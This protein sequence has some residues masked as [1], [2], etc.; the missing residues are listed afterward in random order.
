MSEI[1]AGAGG[2]SV[3]VDACAGD[4]Q[5]FGK[6]GREIDALALTYEIYRGDRTDQCG[7]AQWPV[8]HAPQVLVELRGGTSLDGG[9]PGA[10]GTQ[11]QTVE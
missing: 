2:P 3:E 9:I 10:V 11:G 4:A 8:E 7:W 1:S 6:S 5:C